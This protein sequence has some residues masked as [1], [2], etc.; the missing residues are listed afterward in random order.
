VIRTGIVLPTFRQTPADALEAAHSA[1]AAGVDGV[2]CY[3][4]IWPLGQPG[5]P[6]LAPFP[7]L[8]TLAASGDVPPTPGGGPYFGT[9]VARIGLVPNGVLLGQFHALDHL[10]PGRIIAGLGTGDR[11]SEAENRAYGIPFGPAAE[12]RREMVELGLALRALGIAV[13]VAGGL[14][15]RTVETRAVGAALNVWDAPPALVA[16]RCQGPEAV[17]VTWG[18]P[19]PK[20]DDSLEASIVA[21]AHAGATWAIFGW[22]ID[23]AALAKAAR[24]AG[25]GRQ[26]RKQAGDAGGERSSKG[27]GV[28][29]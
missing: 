10:A 3:D 11:L 21:L 8:A 1:F 19:A 18:G 9:L 2:F 14:A 22:P 17:E 29:S 24:A 4:H 13:W 28:G 27:R 20:G 23:P 5:R 15:A 7:I 26:T 25:D 12:R 6:A 16:S